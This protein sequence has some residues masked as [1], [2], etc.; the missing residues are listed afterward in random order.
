MSD[1]LRFY[2]HQQI[3]AEDEA[4]VLAAMRSD[5]L[6]QGPMVERFESALCEYTGAKHAI[7]CSNGTVALYLLALSSV[8]DFESEVVTSPLSFVA[9]ANAFMLAG[10][11]VTFADVDPATGN[12]APGKVAGDV[13]VP[14]H[15]AGRACDLSGVERHVVSVDLSSMDLD[16]GIVGTAVR[17]SR[18]PIV[19]EDACHALG[20]MDYDGCSRVGSCAHSLATVFSFHAVKPICTGEGGAI[21]T[22][23]DN[24][25]AELRSLRDHGREG[26]LMVRL[27]INGRMTDMQAALGLSQLKRCDEMRDRRCDLAAEYCMRLGQMD[28]CRCNHD[29]GSGV[30]QDQCR[31]AHHLYP[32]RIKNGRRDAVK[33]ALNARGI[34]AQS[35]YSPPI[36][37]H[38]FY[39]QLGYKEGDYPNAEAFAAEELSLP[40]HAGMEAGD[41]ERVVAALR[42]VL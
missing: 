38:P 31:T 22:N 27:G 23:D 6:T 17:D 15:F 2:S 36:H 7:A 21:T 33:A 34:G 25:A 18:P 19:I 35:H 14:V 42:E 8:L 16:R 5:Y 20:A 4:A 3:T 13:I 32:I 1:A 28:C 39:R 11:Q 12:M 41:V 30:P 37:L 24:L 10:H 40:L 29:P 9:T 26:G